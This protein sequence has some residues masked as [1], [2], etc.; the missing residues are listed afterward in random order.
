M[1]N[2]FQNGP[3]Q[4]NIDGGLTNANPLKNAVDYM[5]MNQSQQNERMEYMG[6][7]PTSYADMK[8]ENAFNNM[9]LN[10]KQYMQN[11]Q[12]MQQN[13]NLINMNIENN[14]QHQDINS[15]NNLI[16]INANQKNFQNQ[17]FYRNQNMYFGGGMPSQIHPMLMDFNKSLQN[18][19]NQIKTEEKINENKE[20]NI[21]NNVF[22]DIIEI[23]ESQD[24]ERHH[25]SEFLKFIKK[26]NTGEIK[27]N[28]QA[29]DIEVNHKELNVE[30]QLKKEYEEGD[31]NDERKLEEMW[32]RLESNLNDIDYNMEYGSQEPL[33]DRL[34]LS[35]NRFLNND[36]KED[37]ID[38][39][40]EYLEKGDSQSARMALEAEV[41][42]NADNAEAW[43][44]LGKMHT[45]NDRDDLAMQC[46]FKANEVD[47]FNGDALLALGISCTNEFDEFD[48]MVHIA[49]WM[50]LHAAYN[51]FF[52]KENPVLNYD[53]IRFE[54]END[55]PDEDYYAKAIRIQNLKS[56]FYSEM[57]NLMEFILNDNSKDLDLLIAM[58]ISNF[59]QHNNDRA[60]INFRRAVDVFPNDYTAW[61]K[62]GAILAHSNMNEEAINTYKKAISLK[63]NFPRC[64][65]NM[66]LAYFNL[67]NYDEAIRCFLTALK[68]NKDIDHVWS[69]LNSVLIAQDKTKLS[70]LVYTRKLDELLKI[71]G[72]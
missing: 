71:F 67:K 7:R 59:I 4:A 46:F 69:Y 70:E 10:N 15:G 33:R 28:Q 3:K 50:K 9:D 5:A 22:K 44:N 58:G 25:S 29:N 52:D 16:D 40:K 12:P 24:D 45:D 34:F 62:L 51:K 11:H 47:P 35:E 41:N 66:G 54:M 43:L 31:I 14:F 13:M 55:R 64:W 60:I 37:L 8:L 26:L 20:Q 21:D 6:Q 72:V 63:S 17:N 32:N 42:K 30:N 19:N 38:L 27:L 61:N 2:L 48:A 68:G 39:A 23:M 1:N 49:N 36:Y 57:G 65:S 56:N 53:M 18:E